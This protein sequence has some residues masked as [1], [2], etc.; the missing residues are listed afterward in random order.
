MNGREVNQVNWIRKRWTEYRPYASPSCILGKGGQKK[1]GFQVNREEKLVR[2]I[3]NVWSS[4]KAKFFLKNICSWKQL[5]RKKKERN[6]SPL[7][8]CTLPS[9]CLFALLPH[10]SLSND[11]PRPHFLLWAFANLQSSKRSPSP[12]L[13]SCLIS[14]V[15]KILTYWSTFPLWLLGKFFQ[16]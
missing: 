5:D 6:R 16:A 15:R 14:A 11:S 9:L 12:I 7:R 13:C 8:C 3:W 10:V 1:A 2:W 4:Y